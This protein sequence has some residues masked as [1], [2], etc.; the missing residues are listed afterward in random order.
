M[1]VRERERERERA[2][3]YVLPLLAVRS[4]PQCDG[5]KV[6]R[7]KMLDITKI[8]NFHNFPY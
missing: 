6:I 7:A 3:E 5:E 4:M 8:V 1:Y 2:I